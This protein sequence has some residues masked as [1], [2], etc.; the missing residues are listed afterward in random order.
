MSGVTDFWNAM[1]VV[2]NTGACICINVVANGYKQLLS[3]SQG[4]RNVPNAHTTDT[5]NLNVCAHSTTTLG[6]GIFR[7][8]DF[9]QSM[10]LALTG[11]GTLRFNGTAQEHG[12]DFSQIVSWDG[13]GNVTTPNSVYWNF[14]SSTA[15]VLT[16]T[17][18]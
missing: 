17:I 10:E 16:I 2:N 6:C 15:S 18:N 7:N 9:D 13:G 5:Y 1:Q 14:N 8:S 4:M 11:Y 12:D 3:P